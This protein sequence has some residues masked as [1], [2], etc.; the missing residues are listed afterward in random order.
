MEAGNGT[1]GVASGEVPDT[2]VGGEVLMDG[3]G[4]TSLGVRDEDSVEAGRVAT[5][6]EGADFCEEVDDNLVGE[7]ASAAPEF[8]M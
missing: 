4:T 7:E 2:I 1:V 5:V 8:W 3:E 6:G